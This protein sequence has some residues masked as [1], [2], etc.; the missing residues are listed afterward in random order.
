MKVLIIDDEPFILNGLANIVQKHVSVQRDYLCAANGIAALELAADFQPDLVITDICMPGMDGI[1]VINEFKKLNLCSRFVILTGH[2]DFEY[3]RQ[4]IHLKAIDYILKPID[5]EKLNG[6]LSHVS[7]ELAIEQ[8]RVKNQEL[9]KIRDVMLY[10]TPLEEV[11]ISDQFIK[12]LLPFPYFTVILLMQDG[13][14]IQLTCHMLKKKLLSYYDCVHFFTMPNKKQV[15]VLCNSK[16]SLKSHEI[17]LIHHDLS[18]FV[19]G[20]QVVDMHIGISQSSEDLSQ[21]NSLYANA[22]KAL[23]FYK[24]LAEA[25]QG[26]FF[27]ELQSLSDLY[28][29]ELLSLLKQYDRPRCE[30][31]IADYL[32]RM[33]HDSR[34]D[35]RYIQAVYSIIL[36][37][38]CTYLSNQGLAAE[39]ILKENRDIM[40]DCSIIVDFESLK[41]AITKL[42]MIVQKISK[43]DT[44]G[45]NTNDNVKNMLAYIEK[46]FM[47][48]ISLDTMAEAIHLHPNY[49]SSLF[50]REIGTSFIQ[51]LHQYRI[52]KAKELLVHNMEM[53]LDK[54][55]RLAGYENLNN[56]YKVFKKYCGMTPR[57]F[58]SRGAEEP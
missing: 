11:F 31:Q 4:A 15:V 22:Q 8:A 14:N 47:E 12:D 46:N 45:R 58:R 5:K 56:F 44:I 16:Q 2:A 40:M 52:A 34:A 19:V 9:H 1:A 23:Y 51:Y 36:S 21:L 32:T 42:V 29:F 55:S 37:N 20:S 38:I 27:Q 33:C 18:K 28:S 54:I 30:G 57:E 13:L 3:A 10:D 50:K 35:S 17:N 49:A 24:N 43:N 41:T 26:I 7:E 25:R 39:K 6:L 53:P 48:D